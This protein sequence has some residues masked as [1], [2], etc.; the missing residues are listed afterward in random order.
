MQ[1]YISFFFRLSFW[2]AVAIS[3]YYYVRMT[4]YNRPREMGI[5]K[6]LLSGTFVNIYFYPF[7]LWAG[8]GLSLFFIREYFDKKKKQ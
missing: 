3:T 6:V 2:I 1:K 4:N 8:I 5:F 7:L